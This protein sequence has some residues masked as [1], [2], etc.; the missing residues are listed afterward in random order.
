[1]LLLDKEGRAP[2]GLVRVMTLGDTL[3]LEVILQF[4][5]T[6]ALAGVV[7]ALHLLL[8]RVAMAVPQM[9][10]TVDPILMVKVQAEA[11]LMGVV[12]RES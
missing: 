3:R 7:V 9:V 1:M 6:L 11:H 12:A 8:V 2:S 4:L 5:V 10:K